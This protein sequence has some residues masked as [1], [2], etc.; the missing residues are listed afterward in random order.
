MYTLDDWI[1][2]E[3]ISNEE[4]ARRIGCSGGTLH[5]IRTKRRQPSGELAAK[6]EKGTDRKVKMQTFFGLK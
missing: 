1:R 2:D 6:I 5:N 3:E 4:A